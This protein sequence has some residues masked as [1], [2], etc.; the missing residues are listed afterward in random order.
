ML[1][2]SGGGIPTI[3]F[4]SKRELRRDR[5]LEFASCSGSLKKS[6]YGY[7]VED[8][9]TSTKVGL[10]VTVPTDNAKMIE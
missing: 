9:Y 5:R 1:T 7:I 3:L 4:G 6:I 8:W 2:G 10:V